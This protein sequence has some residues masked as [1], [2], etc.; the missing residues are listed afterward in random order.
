MTVIDIAIATIPGM[1]LL[2]AV[3]IGGDALSALVRNI[4]INRHDLKRLSA[5]AEAARLAYTSQSQRLNEKNKELLAAESNY[6]GI[7]RELQ[8]VR[9]VEAA[10]QD[11][12]NN[13]L[14]E[15]GR[16]QA[17]DFSRWSTA[18]D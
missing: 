17:G 8:G 3:G 1:V 10:L 5:E 12:N 11:P 14:F 7:M 18:A 4:A 9:H 16:P 15:I 6:N 13:T 2:L